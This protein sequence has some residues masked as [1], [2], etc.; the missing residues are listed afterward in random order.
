VDCGKIAWTPQGDGSVRQFW[1]STDAHGQWKTAST[2]G[3]PASD[4]GAGRTIVDFVV[5]TDAGAPA[6]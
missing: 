6:G 3:T 1:E 4:G 2:A 5:G